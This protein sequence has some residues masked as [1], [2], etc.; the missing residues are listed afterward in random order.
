[1]PLCLSPEARSEEAW[2]GQG[3]QRTGLRWGTSDPGILLE[4]WTA[5]GTLLASGAIWA[6]WGSVLLADRSAG[7][8]PTWKSPPAQEDIRRMCVV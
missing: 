3:A 2:T 5:L 4:P 8:G 7:G 6:D 1:M